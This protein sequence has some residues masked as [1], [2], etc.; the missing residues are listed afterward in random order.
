MTALL[1]AAAALAMPSV[2]LLPE[3]RSP[4]VTVQAIVRLP[5]LDEAELMCARAAWASILEGTEEYSAHS[6]RAYAHQAGQPLVALAA[7]DHLLLRT[8]FPR[9][10]IGTAFSM[11]DSILRRPLLL[12]ESLDAAL[13]ALQVP[14]TDP[15]AA[16]LDPSLWR[17]AKPTRE[18]ALGVYRRLVRPDNV[19]LAIGGSFDPS[20]LQAELAR[21]EDWQPAPGGPRVRPWAARLA[22]AMRSPSHVE[23]LEL[24]GPEF[25]S[26]DPA[27]PIK[28]LSAAALGAGRASSLYRVAREKN[29]WS[30]RQEGFL[31]PTPG[32]FRLRLILAHAGQPPALELIEPLREGL[33][34]DV[35]AWTEVDRIRALGIARSWLRD[36]LGAPLI[37]LLPQERALA[38][39]EERT[40]LAAWW[41]IKFGSDLHG[42]AMAERLEKVTLEALRE[43]ALEAVERASA[44]AL[45]AE[46]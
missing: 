33:R 27:F 42:P 7:G 44:R 29:G 26:S 22:H 39:L 45:V 31:Q 14:R 38:S 21:F 37:R 5:K 25:L 17:E 8:V 12:P 43:D 18:E 36:G 6:L 32:G 34:A 20:R 4:H 2:T 30:Y 1:T 46:R 24:A 28:L 16:A 40:H 41:K 13:A 23:T 15:W 11:V 10:Q 9:D 35:K 19:V 3:P